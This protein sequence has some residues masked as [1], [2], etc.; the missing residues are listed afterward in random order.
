VGGGF[1][2]E[3]FDNLGNAAAISDHRAISL[4]ALRNLWQPRN[5][6]DELSSRCRKRRKYG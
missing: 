5:S 3:A 4:I 1:V 2:L 6:F